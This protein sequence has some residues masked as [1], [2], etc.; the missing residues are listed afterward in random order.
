MNPTEQHVNHHLEAIGYENVARSNQNV[1]ANLAAAGDYV[2]A[3]EAMGKAAFAWAKANQLRK[4]A[5]GFQG[6]RA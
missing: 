6:V 3:Y 5:Q 2:G 4:L 1:A